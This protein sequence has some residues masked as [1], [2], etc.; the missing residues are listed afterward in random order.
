MTS[1]KKSMT[2]LWIFAT[3]ILIQIRI[4]FIIEFSCLVS[5]PVPDNDRDYA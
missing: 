5:G 4:I 1:E 2:T 3:G